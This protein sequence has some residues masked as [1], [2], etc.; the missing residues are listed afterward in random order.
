M[1]K[2]ANKYLPSKI[3]ELGM[4]SM[5]RLV[6]TSAWE[7]VKKYWR[8]ICTVFLNYTKDDKTDFEINCSILNDHISKIINDSN[9]STAIRESQRLLATT[10]DST[11]PFEIDDEDDS[12]NDEFND[13][14]LHPNVNSKTN[15]KKN[16][17][18]TGS[19]GK[20]NKSV[21]IH[22]SP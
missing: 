9:S 17:K 21:R 3:R 8:L 14:H 1:R 19:S 4:W 6:N 16:K 12:E 11:D 18:P 7:D 2:K 15:N 5:A 22:I 10:N 13:N 20:N